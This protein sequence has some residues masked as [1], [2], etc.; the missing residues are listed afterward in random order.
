VP[1]KLAH[2]NGAPGLFGFAP[3]DQRVAVDNISVVAN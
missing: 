1:H 3:Q 2:A